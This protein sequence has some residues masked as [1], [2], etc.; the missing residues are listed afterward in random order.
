MVDVILS[1]GHEPIIVDNDSSWPATLRWYKHAAPCQ[2]IYL[3]ANMGHR[4]PWQSGTI[5]E[6]AGDGVYAVSDPDLDLSDVPADALEV[7]AAHL[8][9]HPRL[10]KV[11]LSLRL[12][13]IPADNPQRQAI[14]DHEAQFWPPLR[15]GMHVCALDTTLAVYDARRPYPPGFN[16]PGVWPAARLPHPYT[17]RHHPWYLAPHRQSDEWRYYVEHSERATEWTHR[18]ADAAEP[19]PA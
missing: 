12:D 10:M 5:E 2:V 11:G 18:M 17:A 6:Y 13:D 14:I 19:A 1:W 15:D 7:M 4:A 3:H 9:R 8:E 16:H